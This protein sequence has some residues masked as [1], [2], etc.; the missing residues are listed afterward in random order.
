MS[1]YMVMMSF[2]LHNKNQV[3]DWKALSKEI[4]DDIKQ[5]AGFISRDSGIDETGRVYCL[6]KW[7]SRT[8]Q[9]A[10]RLALESRA[11]WPKMMAYFE[12]IAKLQT[13]ISHNLE[14]F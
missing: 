5:A 4:D 13:S 2:E 9:E 12:S 3:E 1:N 11:D 6:V 10:F 8:D 14:I 7:Q